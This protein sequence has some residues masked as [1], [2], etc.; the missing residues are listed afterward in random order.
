M[1]K[2]PRRILVVP[3]ARNRLLADPSGQQEPTWNHQ[4]SE[5]CGRTPS[6]LKDYKDRRPS[7]DRRERSR[8]QV[9][10]ANRGDLLKV[11]AIA[12]GLCGDP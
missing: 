6:Y 10:Y 7:Q 8:S 2:E 11:Y 9:W 5:E 3:P 12:G 1:Y 4:N